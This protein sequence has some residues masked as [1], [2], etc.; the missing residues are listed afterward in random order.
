MT[1]VKVVS[2]AGHV[3]LDE[4]ASGDQVGSQHYRHCLADRI[5]WAVEDAETEQP[6]SRPP[7][8]PARP[9]PREREPVPA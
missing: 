2:D 7:P 1:R 4:H 3:L 8:G 9:A 6:S 5:L